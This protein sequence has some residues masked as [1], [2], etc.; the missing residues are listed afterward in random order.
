MTTSSIPSNCYLSD[1]VAYDVSSEGLLTSEGMM[2]QLPVVELALATGNAQIETTQLPVE[3]SA[4]IAIPVHQEDR[5]VS[6]VLLVARKPDATVTD[7]IGVFEVWEPIGQYPELALK[8]GFYGA[9]ERFQNVSSFVRF[10]KGNGLPGA[11][12]EQRC[13][14]IHD[15]LADHPGF[16]R[17]AGASADLLRTAIG[18]PVGGKDYQSTVVLI[19]SASTPIARGMEVWAARPETNEFELTSAAYYDLGTDYELPIGTL[20]SS[21]AAPFARVLEEKRAL[22]TDDPQ[23]LLATRSK[24]VALPGPTSGLIIPNFEGETLTSIAIFHF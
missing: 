24:D 22:V 18:I 4:A 20:C 21:D 11:V 16:L 13:A 12:W 7:P 8:S 5:V 9:M 19:S 10:E 2:C 14:V 23:V 6:V 3:A 17:A 1:I 15:Q